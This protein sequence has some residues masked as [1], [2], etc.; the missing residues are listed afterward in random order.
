ML[1]EVAFLLLQS[2]P[3][4]APQTLIPV[5]IVEKGEPQKAKTAKPGKPFY[6]QRRSLAGEAKLLM[7]VSE[8][9]RF[10]DSNNLDDHAPFA[11]YEWAD[12]ALTPGGTAKHRDYVF[13]S[14]YL[15]VGKGV[16]AACF[17]DENR[18][19]KF[20]AVARFE[21][22]IPTSGL[23]F[24]PMT[25][26]G[27]RYADAKDYVPPYSMYTVEQLA[28]GFELDKASGHLHFGIYGGAGYVPVGE[29]VDVDPANLPASINI[30]G[31][32]VEVSAWDG[33]KANVTV[34]S[35]LPQ[36]PVRVELPV[37]KKGRPVGRG[38]AGYVK[39]AVVR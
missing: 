30:Y 17:R 31:A 3:F 37:F 29:I 21:G 39:D 27:Y 34:V 11:V 4:V 19:M 28:I 13:C 7:D 36:I 6:F 25:Q 22:G 24:A 12:A 1:V 2:M 20:E 26:V 15:K 38:H 23:N 8:L 33:K 5:Q 10:R 32:V 16:A 35:P 14:T 9:D 18:D